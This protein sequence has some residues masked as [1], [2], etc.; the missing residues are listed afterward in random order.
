MY[1]LVL[2]CLLKPGKMSSVWILL[3]FELQR[4]HD[5]RL[6]GFATRHGILRNYREVSSFLPLTKWSRLC[7]FYSS[8]SLSPPRT[9]CPF[10][11][12][13]NP[14]LHFYTYSFKCEP[15]GMSRPLGWRTRKTISFKGLFVWTFVYDK[16]NSAETGQ[17]WLK[18]THQR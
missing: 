10:S 4:H 13:G 8:L 6:W 3:F 12:T 18:E 15:R 11:V 1:L 17:A 2:P 16:C 7:N 9:Y 14:L 5:C